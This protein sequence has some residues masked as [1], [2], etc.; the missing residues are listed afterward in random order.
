MMR[1]IV[2]IML[3]RN[4]PDNADGNGSS[5]WWLCRGKIVIHGLC[6]SPMGSKLSQ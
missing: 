4:G 6:A 2:V 3:M 5:D 1:S